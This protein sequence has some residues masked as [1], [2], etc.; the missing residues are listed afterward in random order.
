MTHWKKKRLQ[1]HLC[2]RTLQVFKKS[3]NCEVNL[4]SSFASSDIPLITW[5][6][7]CEKLY[8]KH[9]N[10][11]T[12][13]A[14]WINA[15]QVLLFC[16]YPWHFPLWVVIQANSFWSCL[17]KPEF[18]CVFNMLQHMDMSFHLNTKHDLAWR[19]PISLPTKLVPTIQK[20]IH[21]RKHK[22]NCFLMN[23]HYAN[24]HHE[25]INLGVRFYLPD[26]Q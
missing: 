16:S 20:H 23:S 9:W 3:L 24:A 14:A 6:C 13:T 5:S 15:V 12:D 25:A 7:L 26:H 4:G 17:H 22:D 1:T 18:F 19:K 21:T 2:S 8:F 10:L 11:L